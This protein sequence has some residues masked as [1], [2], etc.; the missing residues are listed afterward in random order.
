MTYKTF[1]AIILLYKQQEEAIDRLYKEK[2]DIIEFVE[3]YNQ[4]LALLLIEIYGETGYD[5]FSWYVYENDYGRRKLEAWDDQ[6]QPIC[7]T[8]KELWEYLEKNCKK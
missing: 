8:E 6:H 2:I 3:P 4:A 7:Q 1:K 5:W